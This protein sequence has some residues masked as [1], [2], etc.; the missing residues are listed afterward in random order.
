VALLKKKEK[1]FVVSDADDMTSGPLKSYGR[2][3]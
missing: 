3:K 2:G 1:E